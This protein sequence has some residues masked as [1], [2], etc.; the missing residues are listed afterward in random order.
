MH[1]QR[2][3]RHCEMSVAY[4][5]PCGKTSMAEIVQG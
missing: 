1:K 4:S 5:G 3:N 2:G